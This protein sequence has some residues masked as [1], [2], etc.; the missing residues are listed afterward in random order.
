MAKTYLRSSFCRSCGWLLPLVRVGR[1]YGTESMKRSS[2]YINIQSH[3]VAEALLH[4]TW[5]VLDTLKVEG[6]DWRAGFL[7]LFI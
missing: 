2:V 5:W 1:L 7:A 4:F 6:G 3:I